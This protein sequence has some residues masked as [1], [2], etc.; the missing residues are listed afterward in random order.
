[1]N[2]FIQTLLFVVLVM[3]VFAQKNYRPAE[4]YTRSGVIQGE[5]DYKNWSVSPKEIRFTPEGG[6]GGTFYVPDISG[7]RV[8]KSKGVWEKYVAFI[9]DIDQSSYRFAI[10]LD[11][12]PDPHWGRDSFFV[13]VLQEGELSLFQLRDPTRKVHYLIRK[14]DGPIQAL[15]YKKYISDDLAHSG[16]NSL[17]IRQI[18]L[19]AGDCREMLPLIGHLKY[20]EKSLLD[21]CTAYNRSSC[22][23]GP[24][25]IF[26]N[27]KDKAVL[28]AYAMAGVNTLQLR[29]NSFADPNR[30]G[31]QEMPPSVN[32][33][34]G[35]GLDL[36]FARTNGRSILSNELFYTSYKT[37]GD[38][39][40]V[41]DA[42][43]QRYFSTEIDLAY[44]KLQTLYRHL[45]SKGKW[46][47]Y[48]GAGIS[49]GLAV[50]ERQTTTIESTFFSTVKTDVFPAVRT[51]D[52]QNGFRSYETGFI[53][54]AG[55]R[56]EKWG[57]EV[58][59]ERNNGFSKLFSV[60][61]P[62]K[63]WHLMIR[64]AF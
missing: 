63:V 20:T 58:R 40:E 27:K 46:K 11:R 48:L 54:C 19:L 4:V 47:P 35:V 13:Q 31:Y 41:T 16:Y 12:S 34:A 59:Y 32:P 36:V 30:L 25:L 1:M 5:I 3:P 45:L 50:K 2:P 52:G 64:Y 15:V 42:N 9:G 44:V 62:V 28:R 14:G 21:F 23:A 29:F 38:Y 7:F 60:A 61:T 18:G 51:S 6:Q 39:L 10:D 8:E 33:A 37:G 49:N 53:G 22:N 24:P 43:Q 56:S 17:Y 55:V 57:A 26:E